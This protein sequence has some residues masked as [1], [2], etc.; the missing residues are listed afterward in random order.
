MSLESYRQNGW[1]SAHQ[2]SASEIRNLLGVADTKISDYKKAKELSADSRLTLAYN[3][4][5][6]SA[7][8]VLAAAGYRAAR[9]GN[10]HYHTIQSLEFTIDPST[11]LLQRIDTLRKKRNQSA[12]DVSGAVSEMEAEGAFALALQV[13]GEVEKWIKA[14][15]RELLP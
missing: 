4:I 11:K 13:R 7:T 8:A 5:T 9:G 2:S 12:Y 10:E 14:H 6:A 1:L 15:R 3:A